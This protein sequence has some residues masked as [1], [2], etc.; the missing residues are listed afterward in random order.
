MLFNSVDYA[1]FFSAVFIASWA[2]ARWARGWL[3]IVLLLVASY[4]FYAHWNW[5]YLPLLFGSATVD[6]LLARAIA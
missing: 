1:I 4:G 3:R 5:R 2:A 6:F